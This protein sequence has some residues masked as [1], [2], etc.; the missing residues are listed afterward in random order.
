MKM[1]GQEYI[2]MAY[3][4]NVKPISSSIEEFST[5]IEGCNMFEQASGVKL[6]RECDLGKVM[7]LPLG[8]WEG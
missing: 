8:K 5:V 3:A 2:V 6:H 4:D 1:Q 7:S